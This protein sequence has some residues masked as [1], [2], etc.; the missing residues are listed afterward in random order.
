[1]QLEIQCIDIHVRNPIYISRLTQTVC[2]LPN[3]PTHMFE[4][5]YCHISAKLMGACV[6]LILESSQHITLVTPLN[7]SYTYKSIMNPDYWTDS[8]I[9][10]SEMS[11]SS[12]K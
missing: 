12:S 9:L 10:H 8:D 1:M 2:Q 7:V 6:K 5:C 3:P 11:V 4:A